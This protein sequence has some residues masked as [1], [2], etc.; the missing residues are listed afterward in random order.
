MKANLRCGALSL[1]LLV[2]CNRPDSDLFGNEP[3]AS[4]P[5]VPNLGGSSSAT[6]GVANNAG[7][8]ATAGA[9]TNPEPTTGGTAPTAGGTAPTAGKPPVE[10][11]AGSSN[12]PVDPGMAGAD[13]GAG[14]SAEPPKPPKPV[15]GNGILE[16]GEQCDD[17]GHTGKD[18]CDD[19]CK[20]ACANFGADAVESDDHH[21]YNGYD[22]ADF[23]RA[24]ADCEARGGH[25]AT[26]SSAVENKLV[27][28]LVNSSKWIG[29][30]EDVAESSEG[31]GAYAWVTGEPF[32]YTN[33]ATREPDQARGRC[34]GLTLNQNCYEHCISMDGEGLWSD[35]RCDISDGYVCEWEPAGAQP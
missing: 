5:S 26:I 29:G 20:V 13:G 14:G 18:G 28:G 21:C 1:L 15:C 4:P 22:S 19:A 31:T 7:S 25:L 24:Q 33:W 2:A 23:A 10:A 8:T 3:P 17:A 6:G 35:A 30:S 32:S 34:M 9:K 11:T 27:R 16:T 12:P